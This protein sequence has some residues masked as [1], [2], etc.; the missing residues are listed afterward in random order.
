[1]NPIDDGGALASARALLARAAP[2]MKRPPRQIGISKQ[3]DVAVLDYVAALRGQFKDATEELLLGG[4]VLARWPRPICLTPEEQL[5][6]SGHG[7][8][9]LLELPGGHSGEEAP[10]HR[11]LTDEFGRCVGF[12]GPWLTWRHYLCHHR[13]FLEAVER[14]ADCAL[15]QFDAEVFSRRKRP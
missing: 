13:E 15:R 1:M 14:F 8:Y 3:A 12:E 4:R 9:L 10:G 5:I 11:I 7:E 6:L 2:G